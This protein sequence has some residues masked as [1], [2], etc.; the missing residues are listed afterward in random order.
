MVTSHKVTIFFVISVTV[1]TVFHAV[2]SK[3]PVCP[4]TEPSIIHIY[5]VLIVGIVKI[6][7]CRQILSSTAHGRNPHIAIIVHSHLQWQ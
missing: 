2:D 3:Q 7:L 4:V 5:K 1:K 6:S